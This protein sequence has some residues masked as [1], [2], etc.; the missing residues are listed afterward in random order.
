MKR[1]GEDNPHFVPNS[2]LSKRK[3]FFLFGILVLF[4]LLWFALFS[5][6]LVKM[7]ETASNKQKSL[8]LEQRMFTLHYQM[9]PVIFC[10]SRLKAF[11]RLYENTPTAISGLPGIL[12][13]LQNLWGFE[14]EPYV[15]EGSSIG[16]D[17]FGIVEREI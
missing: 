4:P 17:K 14:F 13:K 9:K 10:G 7:T 2:P 5:V 1:P 16:A 3:K 12:D 8:E 11:T 6:H 15:F